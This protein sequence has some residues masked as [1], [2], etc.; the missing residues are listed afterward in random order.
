M[1]RAVSTKED[2]GIYMMDG[3]I[4]TEYKV[5]GSVYVQTWY[6][7]WERSRVVENR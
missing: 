3:M 6:E 4:D 5:L 2:D 7:E 1:E